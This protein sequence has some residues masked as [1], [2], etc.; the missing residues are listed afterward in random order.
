MKKLFS[1]FISLFLLSSAYGQ[2]SY[3]KMGMYDVFAHDWA[4][5]KLKGKCG[6]IDKMGK[7]L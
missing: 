5:I 1:V 7:R 6:F 3:D 4:L 2:N